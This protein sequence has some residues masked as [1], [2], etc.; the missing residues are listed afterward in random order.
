MSDV[1]QT[2]ESPNPAAAPKRSGRGSLYALMGLLLGCAAAYFVIPYV[3]TMMMANEM[4]KDFY[5]V[6]IGNPD[7][8]PMPAG[9][10]APGG[11]GPP[12]PLPVSPS[13]SNASA[14]PDTSA[15]KPN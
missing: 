7:G 8:L 15:P 9:M 2:P 6:T 5:K 3:L 12:S 11:G 1:I 14:P 10:V 13:P 4:N